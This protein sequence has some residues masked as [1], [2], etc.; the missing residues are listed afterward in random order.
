MALTNAYTTTSKVFAE[1][2]VPETST[3]R[4]AR[5]EDAINAASRQVDGHCGRRFWQDTEVKV[6]EYYPDDSARCMVDDISTTTGLIVKVDDDDDG[7]YEETLT[8]VTNYILRPLNAADMVPVWPYDEIVIIDTLGTYFPTGRRRPSVQVAA[9]FGWPA[10]P[11]DVMRATTIQAV[12]IY[13]AGDAAFGAVQVGSDGLVHRLGATINPIAAALLE[14]Y[15]KP[16][17]A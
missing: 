7:T 6:R 10:V 17:V 3:D 4:I 5:V 14:P 12:Q 1:L 16:R 13:K 2:G 11:D 9:Q 8:I 15:C